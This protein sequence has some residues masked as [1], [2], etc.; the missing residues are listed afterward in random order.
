V[1]VQDVGVAQGGVERGAGGA[2]EPVPKSRG[3]RT[4]TAVGKPGAPGPPSP[5]S[6]ARGTSGASYVSRVTR[7]PRAAITEHQS[8]TARTTPPSASR[9][10]GM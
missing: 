7:C 2:V 8:S 3:P 9:I 4:T 10:R 5:S 1:Q 6:Q